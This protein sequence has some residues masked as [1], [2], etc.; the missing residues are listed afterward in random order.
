MFSRILTVMSVQL[1]ETRKIVALIAVIE[2][3]N[4]TPSPAKN[5]G[6]ISGSVT[7]RNVVRAARA[8]ALR[9]L[10]EA[11]VDLLQQRDGRAD[12]GRTVAEDVAGD[13]D[14]RRAGEL[15]RRIVEGDQVGDADDR[16]G[17]R[18]VDHRHEL[19]RAPADE[20]LARDEV[21]QQ[22]AVE[23]AE[24]HRERRR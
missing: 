3:M 18:V 19:H 21:A 17:Q 13:D 12:A 1:I 14:E 22:H 9:R 16:A 6:R 5:A 23:A 2:R 4:T 7:R 15:E 20:R 24:R 11:L 10:L 8:Q